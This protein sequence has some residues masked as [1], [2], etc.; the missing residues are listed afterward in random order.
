MP[1]I[2]ATQV[3][4]LRDASNV[5]MMECKKALQDAGGDMD[6]AM[7]LLRERGLAVGAKRA[8]KATNQ[9]AI[10]A[11]TA[12][13]GSAAALAE[14]NCETD[15]VARTAIFQAFAKR[16]AE[17]ACAT[18]A[19]L[20]DLVKDELGA[21][22]AAMGENILVRR[23]VRFVP[24]G[25]GT[26]GTYIH[27]GGKVG[28]LVEV[29]C[30][31]PTTVAQETFKSLAL[32]LTLHVAACSP[33]YLTSSDVPADVV[34]SEREIYAKQVQGKPPQVLAKIVDGKLRKFYSDVCFLEQLFVK[35]Q[36]ETITQL[37]A[38]TGKKLGDTLTIRR[39]VRYQLG[40]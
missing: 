33:Q 32:D 25:T 23:N 21:Q 28:V 6:K 16:M 14:I 19:P 15:F 38:E 24:Q 20:A 2:T 35:E 4:E 9:G 12:A 18:D 34:A 40:A 27:L 22:M 8:G 1:E 36:K 29:G 39:Y 37:L 26:V 3:K 13:D 11:A 7:K 10:V 17:K 5:S 31:K 30:E